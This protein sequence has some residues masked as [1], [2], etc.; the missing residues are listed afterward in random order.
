MS[1]TPKADARRARRHADAVRAL[2]RAEKRLHRAFTAWSNARATMRRYDAE[3]DRELVS[4]SS[5]GA[6]PFDDEL[7]DLAS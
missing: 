5:N 2:E 4:R 3:A 6:P 1:A 7:P